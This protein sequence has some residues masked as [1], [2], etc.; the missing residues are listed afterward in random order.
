MAV[1]SDLP[2]LENAPSSRTP[3]TRSLLDDP[4]PPIGDADRQ[5]NRDPHR[6]GADP[7]DRSRRRSIAIED[8][9][10]YT[11]QRRRHARHRARVRS[12]TSPHKGAVQGASTIEQQFIKNALAGPVAPHDLREAA[13]GRA[14]L[15]ARAQVVEGE[16]PHRSYLNTIYFGNGAYG[17]ESAA[18]T[19]FG[20]DVNHLGCGDARPASCCVAAAAAL[21]GGAARRD[22]RS[23]RPRYD[24]VHAPGGRARRAATSCCG[25]CSSRATSR[26]ASTTQSIAQALPGRNDD[27]AAAS[28]HVEGSTPATSRAG[29]SSR[30]SNATAP[31]A[32]LRRRPAGQDDARPRPAA[33]RRTGGRR[34]PRRAERPDAPR[35]WRSKT[36]PARCARWSAA[37]DYNDNARS[38]SPPRASAS[39]APRS[40]RSTSPRAL[41]DGISPDSTLDLRSRRNSSSPA[42]TAREVHRPQRRRRLHR[43]EHADRRDGLLRQ[44]DLRRSRAQGR[45]QARSRGWRTGWASRTPL[46]TNPAMT[47]GGLKRRRHAARHG[48]RLRDDRPRRP[49]ASAARWPG[50]ASPSIQEVDDRLARARPTAARRRQPRAQRQARAARTASPRPRPRCSK[51]SCTYGTGKARRDRRVRRRQDRH[52]RELRRRL[53]RRLGHRVHGRRVGRLSR[54]ADPD[55]D[56]V[57]RR[58]GAG[59]TFP[60]RDLARL[61]DRLDRASATSARPTER[62][63][64][65]ER[66]PATPHGDAYVPS[67]AEH[68]RRRPRAARRTTATPARHG[69]GT[70]R[71]RPTTGSRPTAAGPLR[72]AATAAPTPAAR[73]GSGPDPGAR[74]GRRWRRRRR[75]AATAPARP[76][77]ARPPVGSGARDR[78][79]DVA[80]PTR[81]RSATAARPP[82][83]MPIRVAGDDSAAARPSGRAR[84]T[85][86]APSQRRVVQVEL[87][88]RAPGSACPG[89]SR[90]RA[91]RSR[92]RRS[93]ISSSPSSGSS[94]RISTAAP[95]PSGSQTAFSS[96]WMP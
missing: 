93:R 50:A 5:Q 28:R 72:T 17:I 9:R 57:Q 85:G 78:P 84:G 51:T 4:R 69:G 83:V 27:P 76:R 26:S 18:Q 29:C 14:G 35:S 6:R 55:D 92:P 43:L 65:A 52:D 68:R 31:G 58:P 39:P 67:G 48:P 89:P 61:H 73:P 62:D 21:G 63:G 10:F 53:V 1:A 64:Q 7:A 32:R 13:R 60:A 54:Q 46:S 45:H 95:T 80:L 40:R 2:S 90:G 77:A 86:S 11:Q 82:C 41:E 56:R 25:R 38:T 81:R 30:S 70:R 87:D 42:R 34:L 88:R 79:R 23:R 33:R 91:S 94:A 22:H 3:R 44:L 71:R 12:R 36:R 49:S 16:D 37:R 20:H 96:A 15:P 8:K 75:A 59:G 24:P 47:I 74:A 66:G 19:Y